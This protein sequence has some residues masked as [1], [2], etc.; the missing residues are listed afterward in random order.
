MSH[1]PSAV[2][3]VAAADLPEPLPPTIKRRANPNLNLAPRCGARTRSGCPCRAPAIQGKLRCR[4]HG[5]RSTGPRTEA[6]L[7]RLRAARTT[8]GAFG[9]AERARDRHSLTVLRRARVLV[10][11]V[12]CVEHLPPALAA[13]L[14]A[15]PPELLPPVYPTRGLTPA[16]GRAVLHA[17]TEALAPWRRAIAAVRQARRGAATRV[18]PLAPVLARC[19]S[20]AGS[21]TAGEEAQTRDEAGMAEAPAPVPA[22]V[23][24]DIAPSTFR[25]RM[26]GTSVEAHA[27]VRIQA[28]PACGADGGGMARALAPECAAAAGD[29][30]PGVA[31]A[32]PV[33][34]QAEVHA[35][36]S[37]SA[38]QVG[39]PA[40]P[41]NR[42]DRRRWKRVERRV[43]RTLGRCAA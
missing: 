12:R 24:D 7:A 2:V 17:E 19:E 35:P 31:S 38:A 5:G 32:V 1:P 16:E 13:R 42:A 9:A 3:P 10:D 27:P 36:E 30:G 41:G 29:D 39:W 37:G 22:A 20:V 18:E 11:A 15:L 6:G 40:V 34:M 28:A 8:H 33:D 26:A 43:N 23:A 25:L 4:M 14:T 21:H